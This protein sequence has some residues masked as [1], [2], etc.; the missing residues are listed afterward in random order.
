MMQV[1]FK[2]IRILKMVS[3]FSIIEIMNMEITHMPRQHEEIT[4]HKW[5]TN[6]QRLKL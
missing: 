1:V 6:S 3:E 2:E 4:K 5:L